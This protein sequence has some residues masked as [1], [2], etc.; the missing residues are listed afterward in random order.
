MGGGENV[1]RTLKSRI[2]NVSTVLSLTLAYNEDSR[3]G[4]SMSF[5]F[6]KTPC[7]SLT[8]KLVPVHYWEDE[9]GLTR[10]GKLFHDLTV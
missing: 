10:D 5:T 7:I 1:S 2:V 8:C 3:R 9:Y 4:I 6:E